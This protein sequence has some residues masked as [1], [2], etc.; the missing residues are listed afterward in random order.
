M[1]RV[2]LWWVS[3][4]AANY[5]WAQRECRSF[6][7]QQMLIQSEPSLIT[8]RQAIHEFLRLKESSQTSSL[9]RT[10]EAKIITIPVIVHILYHYPDENISADRV[11]SQIAALNRDFRKLN[12]DTTKIPPPFKSLA[13]DCGIEFRLATV[14][15]AGRA[16]TGIIRKYTPITGWEMDDKIKFSSEMGDD[17]WDATSYLNIWVGTM[18][19]TN[20]YSSSPGDPAK[21]DGIVISNRAFGVA[22]SGTYGNGRTSVH[23]AGHWLGLRHLWGDTYCGDDGV[24][25]TP[26]QQT[27]TSGCP[28]S[29]RISCGNG[30]FGDMYMNYMDFTNDDCLVMFTEGQKQKMQA[31]FEPGG[32]R[33]SFLSSNGLGIPT[34]D[35]FPLPETAPQWLHIQVFPNPVKSDLTINLEYDPR[36]IGKEIKLI[37][38]LGQVQ[39]RTTITSKTLKLDLSHLKPGVYF[40]SAEKESERMLKKIIKL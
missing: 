10:A 13:A 39:L 24:A 26:K 9:E 2:V 5:V 20:G 22:G 28:S 6:E 16:T 38:I 3:L 29:V 23:E 35:Q 15:A 21:K 12:D 18:Q 14:D 25:D 32:P 30:P 11:N 40:I 27:F 4:F 33:Y 17:A 37:N 34:I 1:K 7:Y 36:W 8:S 31:L 19:T